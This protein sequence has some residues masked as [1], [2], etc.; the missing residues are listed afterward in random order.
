MSESQHLKPGSL[1][2]TRYGAR[3]YL[4]PER[5]SLSVIQQHI[6]VIEKPGDTKRD[7]HSLDSSQIGHTTTA[8]G[9]VGHNNRLISKTVIDYLM[10][11]H[12]G[13][14]ECFGGPLMYQT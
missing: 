10:P 11:V 9:T 12:D 13:D 5:F 6:T 4:G 3:H 14:G 2:R 7:L 8:E 1:H